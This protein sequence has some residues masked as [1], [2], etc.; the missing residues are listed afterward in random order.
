MSE[1]ADRYEKPGAGN[2]PQFASLREDFARVFGG[3]DADDNPH[4]DAPIHI[5]RS[6]GRVNLIGEHNRLQ[7]GPGL[8][9]G[10][11]AAGDVRVPAAERRAGAGL[12][13][14]LR[15]VDHDVHGRRGPGGAEVDELPARAGR[16]PAPARRGA[17]GGGRLPHVEPAGR[18]RP[19]QQR[20]VGGRH[21]PADAP[22]QRRRPR[23]RGDG[24]ALP[25]GGA[26]VRRRPVRDHGPG[27]RRG[28]AGGARDAA[29]LPV[30]GDDARS[31]A[32]RGRGG[33]RVRQQG[34]RTS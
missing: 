15:L 4:N 32:G 33:D 17:D 23:R 5:L 29:G 28:G 30:A 7:R 18:G 1:P 11:R 21:V 22:P 9:D 12:Q 8:P 13:R 6:P 26:G 25:A 2:D 20:G 34:G 14:Q 3:D 27:D 16:A 19:Q 31:A 10:D 24:E